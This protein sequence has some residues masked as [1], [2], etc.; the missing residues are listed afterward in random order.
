M[1]VTVDVKEAFAPLA[2]MR[3]I[4]LHRRPCLVHG[5]SYGVRRGPL[6]RRSH[7]RP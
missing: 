6:D 3:N 1:V 5:L 2:E 7:R 4:A